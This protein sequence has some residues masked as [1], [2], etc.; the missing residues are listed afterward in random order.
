MKK[1]Y[2]TPELEITTFETEDIITLSNANE[3]DGQEFDP[4]EW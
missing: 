2:N 3:P 4:S 1:K